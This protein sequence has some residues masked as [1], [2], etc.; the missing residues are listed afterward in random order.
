VQLKGL[1]KARQGHR[2]REN[3]KNKLKNVEGGKEGGAASKEREPKKDIGLLYE[4]KEKVGGRL[5]GSNI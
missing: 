1:V 2:G 4:R 5:K 3:E